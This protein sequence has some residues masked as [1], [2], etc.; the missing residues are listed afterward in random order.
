MFEIVEASTIPST[1]RSVTRTPRRDLSHLTALVEAIKALPIDRAIRMTVEAPVT[2]AP[3]N[4]RYRKALVTFKAD[5]R[6]LANTETHRVGFRTIQPAD[7]TVND[8][9]LYITYGPKPV[10]DGE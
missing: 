4:H 5:L 3:T 10:A 1:R 9:D 6:M 2:P 7:D 8:V